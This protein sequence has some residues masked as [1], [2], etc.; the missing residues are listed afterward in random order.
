MSTR[1]SGDQLQVIPGNLEGN[2]EDTGDD[3]L[4]FK[5]P[6]N[7]EFNP[8]QKGANVP[9]RK[10]VLGRGLSALLTSSAVPVDLSNI[11]LAGVGGNA[12]TEQEKPIKQG[13]EKLPSGKS[14]NTREQ[15]AASLPKPFPADDTPPPVPSPF[16]PPAPTAVTAGAT[17]A[18]GIGAASN[19]GAAFGEDD[20]LID[21]GLV[22]LSV[23]RVRANPDQPRRTFP[24]AELEDLSE[25]IKKTGLL[26]PLVVRRRKGESGQLAAYEI[27]AGERRFRA[28]KMAGLVKIPAILKQ[29]NDQEALEI[30]II[31][32]VQRSNLNPIEEALAYQ[33]L[34]DTFGSTQ[35]EVAEKVGKDRA[36]VA[37]LLRLL[38]LDPSVQEMI[39]RGDLSAGHGRTLL[40][41]ESPE[42]QR[43]VA[44]RILDEGLSVR[45]AELLS[46]G[47]TLERDRP[48]AIPGAS[49]VPGAS[50]IPG[51]RIPATAPG[52][53]SKPAPKV[54][55][56]P[57][58]LALEEELRRTL[59]TKVSLQFSEAG[60]GE[61]R[62]SFYS[63]EELEGIVEMFRE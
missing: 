12:L 5:F 63:V 37:N 22:Y 17:S 20:G 59:G 43:T 15:K 54:Q 42:L 62:I 61:L 25:T 18:S 52:G 10:S 33:R 34:V 39:V 51:I 31:E 19:P 55:K 30:G 7:R 41:A 29:L 16:T 26:Q 3:A 60:R 21:G 35:N 44:K 36:S 45:E 56:S 40:R 11:P 13:S 6:S 38:K 27:V 9:R 8:P 2:D 23:D 14:T 28:A 53:E 48:V 46:Q 1:R 49:V 58:I 50:E 57:E 32:N 47:G 24:Q 4:E